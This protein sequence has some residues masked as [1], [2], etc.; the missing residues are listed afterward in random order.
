MMLGVV[1]ATTGFAAGLS[2][3]SKASFD[4]LTPESALLKKMADPSKSTSPVFNLNRDKSEKRNATGTD[5]EGLWMQIAYSL[6]ENPKISSS[7]TVER[8]VA[9]DDKVIVRGIYGDIPVNGRISNNCLII[10]KQKLA[11]SSAYNEDVMFVPVFLETDSEGHITGYPEQTDLILSINKINMIYNDAGDMMQMSLM[12]PENSRYGYMIKVTAGYF[13]FNYGI[14]LSTLEEFA[15]LQAKI[16]SWREDAAP[17]KLISD[18]WQYKG[19][20]HFTD[21]WMNAGL[22]GDA[23]CYFNRKDPNKIL[24]HNPYR[25]IIGDGDPTVTEDGDILLDITDPSCVVVKPLVFSGLRDV[26]NSEAGYYNDNSGYNKLYMYN[27]AGNYHYL[28]N[29][30]IDDI[31]AYYAA[32]NIE[33]STFDG[34]YT[35]TIKDP[36]FSVDYDILDKIYWVDENG[37]KVNMTATIKLPGWELEGGVPC[38]CAVLYDCENPGDWTALEKGFEK[39]VS[40][41]GGDG[42]EFTVTTDKASSTTNPVSP[43]A[44]STWRVY[45]N[46]NFTIKATNAL[47]NRVTITYDDD[48]NNGQY[49][50]ALTVSDG[51]TTY[52]KFPTYYIDSDNLSSLTA[53]ASEKQVRIKRMVVDYI[54]PPSSL[55]EPEPEPEP[56]PSIV[57]NY[58][59][60][61]LS[62]GE[63]IELG[64]EAF[65]NLDGIYK[66]SEDFTI[67]GDA[68]SLEAVADSNIFSLS[69]KQCYLLD[70]PDAD[71]KYTKSITIDQTPLN[72][73]VS[74][75]LLESHEIQN[76]DSSIQITV[77]GEKDSFNFTIHL[78]N[79]EASAYNDPEGSVVVFEIEN[80]GEWTPVEVETVTDPDSENPTVTKVITGYTQTRELE[81][82]TFTITTDK[83]EST[84]TLLP[85]D[86]NSYAWRVY[87]G[88]KLKIE[89]SKK[90]MT[91]LVITYDSYNN[92][93]Y[94]GAMAL[95]EGWTGEL[96]DTVYSVSHEGSYLFEAVSADKQVRIKRIVALVADEVIPEPEPEPVIPDYNDPEG[97]T[98]VFTIEQPG[99]WTEVEGILDEDAEYVAPVVVGYTQTRELEDVTVTITTNQD[100]SATPLLPPNNNAYAWRVYKGSNFKIESDGKYMTGVII[101][102][103]TYNDGQY[104]GE[105]DLGEGWSG[106]L[107]DSVYTCNTRGSYLFEAKARE[108]QVRIKHVAVIFQEGEIPEDPEDPEDPTP[109]EPTVAT[110][111]MKIEGSYTSKITTKGDSSIEVGFD[112]DDYWNVDTLIFNGED[113]TDDYVDGR[114]V[115]PGL[116][117]NAEMSV[118]LS[119]AGTVEVLEGDNVKELEEGRI[120]LSLADGKIVIRGLVE[121]DDICLYNL[122]GQIIKRPAISTDTIMIGVDMSGAYILR[123]NKTAYKVNL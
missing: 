34:K 3:A 120:S 55:E 112:L 4:V 72:L 96:M 7:L 35:I 109:E 30:S 37:D 95:G 70:G 51:W 66:F 27:G 81:D 18:E 8:L 64:K 14:S 25:R 105:L 65:E 74:G 21:G 56:S 75:T 57:V 99:D 19:L 111:T 15:E 119:F 79:K 44:Y 12:E 90:Q 117:E 43:A 32:N 63:V 48:N 59:G 108:K 115:I 53:T 68:A 91:R 13:A 98:V 60:K 80:P 67:D 114:F 97:S 39:V 20:A 88:S 46:S 24:L 2:S 118:T 103:D 77:K 73:S 6:L 10:P 87:K 61:N 69:A 52:E 58:N 116:K 16:G 84:S 104:T 11:Y 23:H 49:T 71:G 22:S 38:Y 92:N 78:L 41:A 100:E 62:N 50:G 28:G 5:P 9:N 94:V 33:T 40:G 36:Y 101:T 122:A 113:C 93:Q 83:N 17:F 106:E 54:L 123:V 82:V 29:N 107:T 110:L 121:G 102:Y 76:L 26:R 85:P 45:K 86:N 1:M 47:I 31:K 89:S 42:V